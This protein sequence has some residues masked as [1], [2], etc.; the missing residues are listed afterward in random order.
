MKGGK[1]IV[2]DKRDWEGRLTPLV[3]MTIRKKKA[4]RRGQ[5]SQNFERKRGE[6]VLLLGSSSRLKGIDQK[7]MIRGKM[8]STKNADKG[9]RKL[10]TF[11]WKLLKREGNHLKKLKEGQIVKDN[12]NATKA[13]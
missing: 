3:P 2:K 4:K 9:R 6:G 1:G 5:F 13:P 7:T 11:V 12:G 10:K 8:V